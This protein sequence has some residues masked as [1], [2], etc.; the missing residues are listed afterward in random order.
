MDKN[1]EIILEFCKQCV[2]AKIVYEK[3]VTLYESGSH[4]LELLEAIAN[5]FFLDL[6]S[7]LR[8]S[9]FLQISKITDPA[10][11]YHHDNLTVDFIVHELPWP[12]NLKI[13]LESLAGSLS[14]FR[15]YIID[16]RR[17][18]IAHS[19]L[20]AQI[21]GGNL[22][23]FPAGEETKFWNNL[24]KFIDIIHNHYIGGPYSIDVVPQYDTPDL[25]EA[26]KR[27][28]DYDDYFQNNLQKKL[29]RENKM[30][31]RDA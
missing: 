22:G 11:T 25:I 13:E 21:S 24:Q 10:K 17:K 26:L 23:A 3:F 14:G 8:E 5:N 2:W 20:K 12:K 18:I 16:A 19:D 30:R 1:K 31:Y 28:V 7:I 27:S 29:I 4:R 9:I 15:K 6:Q